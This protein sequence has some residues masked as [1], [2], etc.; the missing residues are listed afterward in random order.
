MK[1]QPL[2]DPSAACS[3]AHANQQPNTSCGFP[4]FETSATA[5]RGTTAKASTRYAINNNY[6]HRFCRL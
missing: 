1:L 6:G 3:A 5:L 4:I 2:V